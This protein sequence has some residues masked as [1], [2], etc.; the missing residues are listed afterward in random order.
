[1]Y[2][3]QRVSIRFN[4]ERWNKQRRVY[5]TTLFI[6]TVTFRKTTAISGPLYYVAFSKLSNIN[7]SYIVFARKI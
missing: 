2:T 6:D 5:K 3:K 1:M 7:C 4:S